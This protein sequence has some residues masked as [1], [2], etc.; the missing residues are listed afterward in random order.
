MISP[1]SSLISLGFVGLFPAFVALV[2]VI[3]TD[4]HV[5]SSLVICTIISILGFFATKSVIP[6]I[7]KFTLRAGLSGRDINKKGS[8]EGE[9]DIPESLGLAPGV[10]F[11]VCLILFE[12]LHY[13]DVTTF[14]HDL[15]RGRFDVSSVSFSGAS[16]A[17]LVDYNAALATICFMLFLGFADDVLDIP[18]RVKL[19]LPCLASLPLMTA[20]SGGTGVIVPKPLVAILGLP[21]YLELGL[22]YRVY[23]V[24]LVIFCSNSINILAGINGLEA[25]QTFII[26]CAVLLHNMVQLAGS[27]GAIPDVRDG[28]LFSAYLML[29]LAF[30]TLG[31]LVFNWYPSTVFVGDTFTYFAGMTLSVAGILGHFSETLL[32]R[33]ET[34]PLRNRAQP[35]APTPSLRARLS[36]RSPGILYSANPQ[37]C[38]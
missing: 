2:R 32:V 10:V 16:D 23:L 15:A 24:A 27:A 13:Y 22:I 31:I 25:G 14:V 12:L 29:P 20:Y 9:K 18:W 7:K 5:G 4:A 33:V 6:L 28:H 8:K 3:N 34:R 1:N 38:L 30:N 35:C 17:W 19:L 11:L 36:V 37:L 21:S 26:A